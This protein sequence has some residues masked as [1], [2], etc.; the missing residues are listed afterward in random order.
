MLSAAGIHRKPCRKPHPSAN[1]DHQI[2][3]GRCA[4]NGNL[5]SVIVLSTQ[6][7]KKRME[8]GFNVRCYFQIQLFRRLERPQGYFFCFDHLRWLWY[9]ERLTASITV[10]CHVFSG[11]LTLFAVNHSSTQWRLQIS[12]IVAVKLLLS[13]LQWASFSAMMEDLGISLRCYEGIRKRSWPYCRA[14]S[15]CVLC[16]PRSAPKRVDSSMWAQQASLWKTHR[17]LTRLD[18]SGYSNQTCLHHWKLLHH[19]SPFSLYLIRNT[20]LKILNKITKA[21]KWQAWRNSKCLL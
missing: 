1:R 5:L 2:E 21:Q 9:C 12:F 18:Y 13:L 6:I 7:K 20:L 16:Q 10:L 17:S 4:L 19:Q 3:M 14:K 11:D 15:E 8:K